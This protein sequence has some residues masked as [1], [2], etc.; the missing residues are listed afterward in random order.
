MPSDRKASSHCK[1]NSSKF[2]DTSG[3]RFLLPFEFDR[4]QHPVPD[5]LSFLVVEHFDVV[6][7]VL[8]GLDAGFVCPAPYPFTL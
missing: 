3:F 7:H 6:E 5:V 8:P 1:L 4:R 2:I